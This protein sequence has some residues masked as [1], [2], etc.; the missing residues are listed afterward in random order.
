MTLLKK[1]FFIFILFFLSI[2]FLNAEEKVSYIDIDSVLSKSKAGSKLLEAIKKEEELKIN[3]FKLNDDNFKN[4]EKKI[5]AKKNLISKEEF[6]KEIRTLQAKFQKYKKTKINEIDELKKKRNKNI[7]N[8]LN[9]INPIIEKYMADNS[10]YMLI[11]KKN[12]FIASVEYDITNNLIEL[13]D[14]QIK[15]VEIK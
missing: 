9:L 7:V 10:I 6:D 8:F 3:E 13:I 5:L 15:N 1:F 14:N 4:E 11:D 12:V 2:S